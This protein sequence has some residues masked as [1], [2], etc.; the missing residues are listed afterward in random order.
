VSIFQ[1]VDP[2]SR[3]VVS[4]DTRAFLEEAYGSRR[5]GDAWTDHPLAVAR[6]LHEDGQPDTLVRA[7]LLHD[8][9]EDTEVTTA[10]I[11]ERFGR[12]VARLVEALTQDPAI[13]DYERRKAALREQ[14]LAAGRDAATVALADKAAKLAKEAGRPKQSRLEH[15]RAT[16]AGIEQRFGPSPLSERLRDELQRFSD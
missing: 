15:Y 7:G 8:V 6:L 3:E 5:H 13:A 1:H 10:E 11:R 12:E 14:I 16:L 4:A 2:V 9:L